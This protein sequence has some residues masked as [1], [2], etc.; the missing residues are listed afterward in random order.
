[1]KDQYIKVRKQIIESNLT[2]RSTVDFSFFYSYFLEKSG[3]RI[4][5]RTFQRIFFQGDFEAVVQYLD[6]QFGVTIL[7]DV[8]GAELK[9]IE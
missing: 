1:M 7:I 3:T 6:K 5:P 4:D 9:L 8:D 2:G